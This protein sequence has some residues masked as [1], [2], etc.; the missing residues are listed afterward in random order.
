M[1]YQ[2]RP[3]TDDDGDFVVSSWLYSYARSAYGIAHGYHVTDSVEG[4]P[5]RPESARWSEYWARHR[6]I[7]LALIA[8]SDVV[9]ACDAGEPDKIWGWAC[10]SADVVHYALVK[11][12]IHRGSAALDERG[13]WHVTTG[14]S[15]DIYR[16][17]LGDRLTRACGYTHEL[18]DM[19]RRELA[20]Q[21]VRQPREWYADTTW[22]A[23]S[24]LKGAA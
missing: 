4:L 17:L 11:R 20:V 6:P 16:A 13:A 10:T 12:S 21:G 14:L 15:G 1:T 23:R 7:V 9:I 24:A 8:E 22:L 18:V 19:R 2:L 3:Y 5:R